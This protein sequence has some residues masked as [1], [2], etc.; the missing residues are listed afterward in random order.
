VSID[1][2]AE[3][4]GGPV[5]VT[6]ED[7]GSLCRRALRRAGAGERAA[8]LLTGA[9]LFAEDR[10]K[11]AVGVTHLL[12]H[13]DALGAGRIDGS[14]RPEVRRAARAA[15]VSDAR[16]GFAHPGFDEAFPLL[17]EAAQQCG[18]AVFSQR[19]A[20]TCSGLGWF[21]HRVAGA[22]VTVRAAAARGQ[23]LP[24]GTAID[25]DGDPTT[26]PV[27][28]LAGSLLPFG[29]YK[30][31]NIALLVELLSGLAGG[32]WGLDAPPF[33]SGGSSPSVGM[34]VIALDPSAFDEDYLQRSGDYLRRLEE[35][36]VRLPGGARHHR[37][38]S[39][40]SPPRCSARCATRPEQLQATPRR[41]GG[42]RGDPRPGRRGRGTGRDRNRPRPARLRT[43]RPRAR[44]RTRGRGTDEERADARWPGEHR[45][46]VRLPR[47]TERGAGHRPRL[48]AE[49]F[50]PTTYGIAHQGRT[51]VAG[52][53]D[54]VVAGLDLR[55]DE[56]TAL[57][58]VLS[59]AVA[60]YR[61]NTHAGQLAPLSADLARETV[62]QRFA[63]L[64]PVTRRIVETAVQGGSVGRSQDL[65]A[66][67]ALRYFASYPAREQQNRLLVHGACRR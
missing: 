8:A 19:G 63:D 20:Y 18:V 13:V 51:S 25:A 61:A 47:D 2:P 14:S 54:A 50:R 55:S 11:G 16:G 42:G 62:A 32:E 6:R 33:Q 34:T 27:A 7:L 45:C 3:A 12:D 41:T 40:T 29:G 36:G 30:G 53:L 37:G 35:L 28:A 46:V 43:R 65:S 58:Q 10:G 67:Y 5:P 22:Y 66:H 38:R 39:S 64:P 24:P 60:E 49:E 44:G 56:A 52:E 59:S 1:R 21:T 17:I 48:S 57:L 31:A 26:D 23:S 15:L 9:T 4:D